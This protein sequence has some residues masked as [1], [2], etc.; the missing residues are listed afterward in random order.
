M[1]RLVDIIRSAV[2]I[3]IFS[4]FCV[5][6]IY[7]IKNEDG[8]PI[9]YKQERIGLNGRP[10]MM[11]KFRSMVVGAHAMK[12][13]LLDKNESDGPTFKIKDDPRITEIGQWIR[14]HSLDEIPQFFNIVKGDMSLVGPRPALP[15]EV[16]AYS[17][18]D[19]ARLKVMPGL[20]GLWQVGGR[21]NLTYEEMIDLDLQYVRHQGLLMDIKIMLLTI[22]Q[23]FY[24]RDSGAY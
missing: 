15:E 16:A 19:R 13:T 6:I 17:K 22:W 1:K 4:P 9:L 7:K 12:D 23:M 10:F 8:G 2:A 18:R 21:S 5:Y 20:T 11:W 3:V 14:K 24:P